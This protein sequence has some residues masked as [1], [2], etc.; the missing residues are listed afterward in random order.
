MD[1]VENKEAIT[2][3]IKIKTIESG[4]IL[5]FSLIMG[6]LISRL[7]SVAKGQGILVESF[8]PNI[9]LTFFF[10]FIIVQFYSL[11]KKNASYD[12]P[13]RTY[14][15][16]AVVMTVVLS[17]CLS[18]FMYFITFLP[19]EVKG[20]VVWLNFIA[21]FGISFLI[22][23]LAGGLFTVLKIETDKEHVIYIKIFFWVIAGLIL[24]DAFS[25]FFLVGKIIEVLLP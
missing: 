3:I 6:S 10:L 7:I 5:L 22:A 16:G 13:Q 20:S 2:E 11:F 1:K 24:L 8:S 4:L 18:L 9:Y 21:Y 25:D 17:M 15:I 19:T 23:M 12:L 14:F